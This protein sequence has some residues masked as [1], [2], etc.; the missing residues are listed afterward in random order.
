MGL[1]ILAWLKGHRWVAIALGGLSLGVVSIGLMMSLQSPRA[2]APVA[3]DA[4]SS[5]SQPVASQHSSSPAL[6]SSSSIATPPANATASS[7][8]P[9]YV[10]V[11]GA[12]NQPGLYQVQATTRIADVIALAKGLQPQA[13]QT[14]LNLAAK[15]TDQQ[16]VY[17]PVKGEQ[18]PA[19]AKQPAGASASSVASGNGISQAATTV[20]SQANASTST[21]PINLNTADVSALQQLAGV[22]QKKAERIIAY[23]DTHGGFKSVDDLKQVSGIGDKTLEKFRDQLTV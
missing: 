23:R 7:V 10:D 20:P 1:E 15:V 6:V 13:D 16:V 19:T 3:D 22:G 18:V 2:P 21:G 11:K 14:Q 12:V 8:G 4:L 9:L 17:V 5:Q